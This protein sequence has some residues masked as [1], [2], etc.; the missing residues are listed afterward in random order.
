MQRLALWLANPVNTRKISAIVA[1]ICAVTW[2]LT[3]EGSPLP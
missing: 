2:W 3:G 1:G